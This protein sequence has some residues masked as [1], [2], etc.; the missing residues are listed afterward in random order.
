MFDVENKHDGLNFVFSSTFQNIDRTW[1]IVTSF[2]ESR[3]RMSASGLFSVNLVLREALTNAVRHGNRSMPEKQVRLSL[4]LPDPA[5][6]EI[7]VEDSGDGFDHKE[8]V[9]HKIRDTE[10]HG[11]GIAIIKKYAD[12]IFFN[13]KGNIIH[14]FI[15]LK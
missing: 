14:I 11:R 15:R 3:F 6:L 13:D 5:V 1:D 8:A 7:A 12:D 2:L 9:M 4:T 10:N